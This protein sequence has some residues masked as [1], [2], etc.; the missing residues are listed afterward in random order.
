MFDIFEEVDRQRGGD[1]E[2]EDHIR[3]M[4]LWYYLSLNH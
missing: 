4:L 3:N 2:Q 1:K